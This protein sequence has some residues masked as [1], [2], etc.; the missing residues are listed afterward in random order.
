[1][2]DYINKIKA[3][4]SEGIYENKRYGISKSVFNKGKSFKIFAEELQG[5][6][7]ISLNYYITNTKEYL[8]PCEMSEQKVLDFLKYVE[9]R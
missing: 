7:L 2:L 9:I 3:G 6:N 1:M 4:Y 5:N 8:K